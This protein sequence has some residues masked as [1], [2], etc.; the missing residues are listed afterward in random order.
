MRS[1]IMV[2][3][4]ALSLLALT[5]VG[6]TAQ[7]KERPYLRDADEIA[8][9]REGWTDEARAEVREKWT[10]YLALSDEQLWSLLPGPMV[11]RAFG[12]SRVVGCPNCRQKAYDV[13]GLLPFKCDIFAA[14]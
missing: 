7:G 11:Y 1:S 8:E 2:T 12:V 5:N 6:A 3:I 14:P 13:G 10:P 4:S 9:L